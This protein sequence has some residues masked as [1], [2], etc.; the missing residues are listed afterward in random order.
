MTHSVSTYLNTSYDVLRR[1]AAKYLGTDPLS[2]G[3]T[4]LVH[5]TVLKFIQ[6]GTTFKDEAHFLYSS[7][8]V[9]RQVIIN[10]ARARTAEKRGGDADRV[11]LDAAMASTEHDPELAVELGQLISELEEIDPRSASAVVMR[12][13][14]GLT[15]AETA[16]LL[17]VSV[18]T[19]ERD[20]AAGRLWLVDR[21]RDE[22]S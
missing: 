8:R 3:T 6:S 5:E 22:R 14:Y 10:R 18:A 13:F 20:Y 21:L 12:S 15:T 2:F 1:T 16:R 7:W 11:E 17:G 4:D 19:A 9:F